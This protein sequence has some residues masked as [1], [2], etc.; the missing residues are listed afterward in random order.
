MRAPAWR[1][2]GRV[3]ARLS[4]RRKL[5]AMVLLPLLVVLPLL[6]LLLLWWSSLALDRLLITKVRADLAVANGY[7]ER[8]L[9]EV[10]TGTA[11]V[12]ESHRLRLA[13]AQA[14]AQWPAALEDFR[15]RSGLDFLHLHGPDGRL[16]AT[17]RGPAPAP[18]APGL[19]PHAPDSLRTS[20]EVLTPE[21]VQALDPAVAARVPVP[22][23]PTRNAAPSPRQQEDRALVLL[24]TQAVRADDGRLLGH[25]QGGLLLN[26]NLG[27]I[28]HIN[29]I[30][31]PEGSLPFG[32]RGTATLFLE[33]VRISTNVRLFAEPGAVSTGGA[34][35]AARGLDAGERA[36]G[37]RVS[38]TV[39]DA[40]LLRGGTWLDRAFV[41]NDWY[42]S[43]YQPLADGSGRPVGMLYVGF[44][45]RPF[46]LLK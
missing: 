27:F 25:V 46:T 37:T 9:G 36:I 40:V 5:L 13:L 45:E 38:Q 28:D 26:R 33:D 20:I 23:L 22:L 35:P 17:Q 19:Q 6:G 43:G 1:Q 8:V 44:S 7:L 41:V 4:I 12:A 21:Q 30:V 31:Y 14:P 42:V 32:S 18:A 2:G 3:F 16:L 39:R 34:G 29:G 24:S 15:R 11:A 10:G